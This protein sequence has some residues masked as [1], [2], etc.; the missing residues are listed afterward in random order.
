MG[1]EG[2]EEM[3]IYENTSHYHTKAGIYANEEG[4]VCITQKL[5]DLNANVIVLTFEEFDNLVAGY[6]MH[7]EE[8]KICL[9]H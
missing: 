4:M 1:E 6:Q 2:G 3:N 8:I 5:A 9:T 7:R